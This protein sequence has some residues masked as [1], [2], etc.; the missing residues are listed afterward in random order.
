MHIISNKCRW[1]IVFLAVFGTFFSAS[2]AR[3]AGRAYTW[4]FNNVGQLGDGTFTNSKLPVTVF[5]GGAPA[6]NTIIAIAGGYRHSLSLASD[7][8]VYGWGQN[9]SGQLGSEAFPGGSPRPVEVDMSGVLAGKTVTAIAAGGL[10]SLALTSEGKV[11]SWGSNDNG[12][13]GAGPIGSSRVPVAV[14]TGGELAGKN[15]VAISAGMYHSLALTSDGGVYAWGDNNYRQ[16][17][18]IDDPA[19]SNV[20]MAI[21]S[22]GVLAGKVITKIAAGLYH[23]LVLANDGKVYGWG[24]NGYFQLGNG[25]GATTRFPVAVSTSGVLSGK[26]V[27]AIAASYLHSLAVTS[28][29]QIY[30]WGNNSYRQLGDGTTADSNV[31][32]AVVLSGGLAGKAITGM[33]AGLFHSV[34]LTADNKVYSWGGGTSE[35]GDYGLN[36]DSATPVELNM[37]GRTVSA[38][39]SGLHHTL[40]IATGGAANQGPSISEIEDKSILVNQ[41][42]GPLNFTVADS[43]TALE[44]LVLTATSDNETLVPQNRISFEGTGA[45]RS[46]VISPA[47]WQAGDANITVTVSDG[48][49]SA[50]DTFAL[51]V[52]APVEPPTITNIGD[53]IIGRNKATGAL[54]FAIGDSATAPEALIVTGSADNKTLVPDDNIVFAGTGAERTVT[55]T[56]AAG[57]VGETTITLTVSDGELSSTDTFVLTV[58]LPDDQTEPTV[59]VTSPADGALLK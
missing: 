58:T 15:V 3:A 6:G 17:G 9:S 46:I 25:T 19:G 35:D 32:V 12:Q 18:S 43:D 28:T 11:Y 57:K 47:A 10:H 33:G 7:G 31:P 40:S 38:I 22:S 59:S 52:T 26:T 53:Q 39:A 55:I 30:S 51:H 37:N 5:G 20:P 27:T 49:F 42:T 45:S 50:S 48:E 13:L 24:Y 44:G 56:P 36:A 54:T 2:A 8:K 23:N 29:G 34:V 4:G 14:Q 21:N 41:S 1:I 16:L